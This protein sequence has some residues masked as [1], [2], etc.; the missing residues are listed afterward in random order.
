[1]YYIFLTETHIE[2]RTSD[3]DIIAPSPKAIDNDPEISGSNRHIP[4]YF[5]LLDSD[6]LNDDPVG[7]R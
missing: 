4:G 2:K 6:L 5:P 7:N 3:I 1:M